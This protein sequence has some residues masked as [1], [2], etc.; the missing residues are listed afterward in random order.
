MSSASVSCGAPGL[1]SKQDGPAPNHSP[2]GAR[3]R[4]ASLPL[5]EKRDGVKGRKAE[6]AGKSDQLELRECALVLT[7]FGLFENERPM[8]QELFSLSK[9]NELKIR[10]ARLLKRQI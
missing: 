3:G 10:R 7:T 9:K 2:E 8:E 5:S 6:R 1:A 4:A